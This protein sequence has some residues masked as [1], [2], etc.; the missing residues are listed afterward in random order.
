MKTETRIKLGKLRR[1]VGSAIAGRPLASPVPPAAPPEP[2]PEVEVVP[3]PHVSPETAHALFRFL[4][5]RAPSAGELEARTAPGHPHW[6]LVADLLR[7]PEHLEHAARAEQPVAARVNTWIPELAPFCHLP[8]TPSPD[9]V[10]VVGQEGMLFL[11]QGANAALDHFRGVAELPD[12]WEASWRALA[13]TRRAQAAAAGAQL[14]MLVVPDKL[15]VE[16][17]RFPE[18]L[19][20][21]GPRPVER[22]LG[23]EL[24]LAY[25]IDELVAVREAGTEVYLRT[26]THL[27]PAGNATLH[28]AACAAMGVADAPDPYARLTR[29]PYVSSGDLGSR[30]APNVVEVMEV[31]GEGPAEVASTNRPAIAARGGHIGTRTTWR[32]P[33]PV[34]PE[35]VVVFGDSYA[36]GE[37]GYQGV[38]YL[39][40]QVFAEV[41]FAW[42]PFGWDDE[43]VRAAGAD[44]VLCQIAERFV[45]RVPHATVSVAEL[46]ER[47]LQRTPPGPQSVMG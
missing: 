9:G 27:T 13:E 28:A 4:L 43:V 36:Y 41:V 46:E 19:K 5:G 2:E 32:N 17:A 24:G 45:V 1:R 7:S 26:D 30:F 31:A 18:A 11:R 3:E 38:A 29:I 20:P 15:A 33:S 34:R 14:G 16:S 37:P 6:M 39:L 35:T 12:D 22:L 21:V 42:A 10:A 8:G 25:P 40:A 47:A 23:L 44:L